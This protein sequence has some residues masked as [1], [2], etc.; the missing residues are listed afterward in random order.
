MYIHVAAKDFIAELSANAQ[1]ESLRVQF[2]A[3]CYDE[4]ILN[5]LCCSAACGG[6]V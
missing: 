6:I 2:P 3:A 5:W 1:I 4:M